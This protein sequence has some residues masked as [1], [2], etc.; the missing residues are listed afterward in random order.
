MPF[1]SSSCLIA[2]ARTSITM[3]NRSGESRYPCLVSDLSEKAF[4]FYQ[5]S[6]MLAVGFL[7][8]SFIMLRYAHSIPTLLGVFITNG[9]CTLSNAFSASSDMIVQ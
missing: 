7:Y 6:M 5:L 2:V 4:S 8:M 1:I 9:C 3:M